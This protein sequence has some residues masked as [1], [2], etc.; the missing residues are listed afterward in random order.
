MVDLVLSSGLYAFARHVGVIE[1]LEFRRIAPDAVVGTS[2][3]AVVGALWLAG[4]RPADIAHLFAEHPP[5]H[6]LM[7]NLRVWEGVL[8]PRRIVEELA[9]RLPPTF[10]DLSRPLAVGVVNA[11]GRHELIR[12]GSLPDVVVASC[13][14]PGLIAPVKVGAE[15]Y[16][17]GGAV[18]RL[19]LDA[20]RELFPGRRTILHEVERTLGKQPERF[21]APEVHIKTSRV[22]A[23]LFSAG[24][25][26]FEKEQ[27]RT[28]ALAALREFEHQG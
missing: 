12:S 15:R 21:A 13:A 2:S 14:V 26:Y 19:G 1:A 24:P 8:S 28:C 11:R 20:W 4:M 25:F 18:D 9:R 7:P 6:W 5:I 3:G 22:S 17:D 16:R 10:E 27:A 23:T